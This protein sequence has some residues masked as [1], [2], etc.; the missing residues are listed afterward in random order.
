M[1]LRNDLFHQ[2]NFG[3]SAPGFGGHGDVFVL[4]YR[5]RDLNRRIIAATLGWDVPFVRSPWWHLGAVP[6]D[7]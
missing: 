7:A 3:Q 4:P 2:V 1:N 6:F 5:L